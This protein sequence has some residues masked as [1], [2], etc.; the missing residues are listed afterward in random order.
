MSAG[1]TVGVIENYNNLNNADK[2]LTLQMI[3][4]CFRD[5]PSTYYSIQSAI[6]RVLKRLSFLFNPYS[7]FAKTMNKRCSSHLGRHLFLE[8]V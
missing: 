5:F 8:N 1:K 3:R 4:T 6:H 2:L 7:V